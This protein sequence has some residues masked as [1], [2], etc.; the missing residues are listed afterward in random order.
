MIPDWYVWTLLAVV[1]AA[2]AAG[3]AAWL[4][5]PRRSERLPMEHVA[6]AALIAT[7]GWEILIDLPGSFSQFFAIGAGIP[8][9]P[10]TSLQLFIIANTAFVLASAAAIAGILRRR[11]WGAALGIGVGAARVTM[12]IL[13]ITSLLTILGA[14]AM[15]DG[16]LGWLAATSALR[17]V[18][19]V[20]AAVLL[21]LPFWR[22]RRTPRSEAID[23]I[24]E[25]DPDAALED[26]P[27]L[28]A[29]AP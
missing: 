2:I 28:I 9:A 13:G 26:G 11:V 8:N 17:A 29:P 5:W 6:A 1:V 7:A 21:A 12:A 24:V 18:P 25:L 16:Q 15:P 4:L 22:E 10:M 19:A 27:E 20:A 23:G 14:E 3:T